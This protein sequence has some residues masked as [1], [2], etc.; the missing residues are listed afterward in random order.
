MDRLFF[1]ISIWTFFSCHAKEKKN[2]LTSIS[3][4]QINTTIRN[5]DNKKISI[6]ISYENY[7]VD[8]FSNKSENVKLSGSPTVKRFHSTI[9]WSIQHFGT[10]FG[11]HFNLARWGCGTSCINGAITD[12]KTGLVYD[13][14]AASLGYEFRI[15]SR[16]LVVNPP[17]ST[18]NYDNCSYCEPELWLWNDHK[19]SFERL[20]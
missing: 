19:K 10:N 11:G 15:N 17:D 12:L 3:A 8:T 20:N 9:K 2:N 1:I 4:K 7:E 6:P 18:G 5:T 13:I 14:P 16:L